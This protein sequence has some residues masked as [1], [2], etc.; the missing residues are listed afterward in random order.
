MQ[1]QQPGGQRQRV[2]VSLPSPE[3]SAPN[4]AL[5]GTV[6]REGEAA[7]S[8]PRAWL[9]IWYETAPYLDNLENHSRGTGWLGICIVGGSTSL[10]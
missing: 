4:A 7:G 5:T 6:C 8:S 2:A 9:H 3:R 1:I 10:T